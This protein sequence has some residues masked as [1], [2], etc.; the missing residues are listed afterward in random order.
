MKQVLVISGK[1]GTGKTTLTAALA[2]LAAKEFSLLLADADVDAANLEILLAPRTEETHP[3]MAGLVVAIDQ[4]CCTQCGRCAEA[5]RFDAILWNEGYH[6][7]ESLCEGCLSCY[8]Q[9]PVDAIIQQSHQSGEWY[10]SMTPYG[11]LYHA[12]LYPGE[13]NSGKL[14]TEL[15][16]AA[17]QDA[18]AGNADLLLIDGP[19]GIGCPVTAACRGTDLAVLV[20]EP[21]VSGRHDLLRVIEVTR[22]F[23]I[24]ACLVL[25]KADLNP[26][27]RMG[28]LADA[29][30]LGVPIIGEIPYDEGMMDALSQAKPVTQ[31]VDLVSRA[32]TSSII[33]IWQ[34]LR[35]MIPKI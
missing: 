22:H 25:N 7:E 26:E 18:Q 12:F 11:T 24:P 28:I 9:C 4:G 19:P 17:C 8:Y 33:S 20:S 34:Q 13:E 3:F 5:C 16:E 1:G 32:T 15:K 21:T 6:V 31:S 29:Q 35:D 27:I 14:V 30:R 2:D 23:N 10:R